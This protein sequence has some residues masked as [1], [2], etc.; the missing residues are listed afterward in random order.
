[1][2]LGRG[3]LEAT[4]VPF[5]TFVNALSQQLGRTVIDK[6]ELK[7]LYDIKLLWTPDAVQGP[8]PL[9]PPPAG[10][11]PPPLADPSGPTVF[12]AVQEQL[13]LKLD[14]TKGPVEVIVIDSVQKPTEN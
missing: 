3:N 7:G 5:A 1:M 14:S 12:T 2:R 6:T 8:G 13:G 10:A 11:E 4:A 9:G